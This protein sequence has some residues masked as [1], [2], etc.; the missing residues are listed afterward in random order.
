M[1]IKVGSSVVHNT[2]N[3]LSVGTVVKIHDDN[4]TKIF[5]VFWPSQSKTTNGFH[6][7][8][9]LKLSSADMIEMPPSNG[10]CWY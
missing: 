5:E 10:D 1:E 7:D 4:G 3:F 9:N 8:L 6:S 2:M